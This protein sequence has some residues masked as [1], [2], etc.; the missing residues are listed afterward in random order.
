MSRWLSELWR[1]NLFME[2]IIAIYKPKG[3][4]SHDIIDEIR[5][6]TGEQR[7]GHAGTL[8]PLA[9][10]VLVVGIGREATKK[11]S[12]TVKKEKEYIAEI[13]FGAEST[14]DDEEGDK[15][16]LEI[17]ELPSREII[18]KALA[19][20]IGKIIQTPPIYSAIKVKGRAAYKSARRGEEIQ[21]KSREVE[22]KEIEMLQYKWPHLELRIVTGPGVYIR[23]LARDLGKELAVGGYLSD[24]ERIRVGNFRKGN[25]ITIEDLR[26]NYV[27]K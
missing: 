16:Y 17:K 3:P 15:T 19:K 22:I 25:S 18:E 24:L 4:T 13:T 26:K 8:D 14:T 10:G 12:E 27:K 20:F 7:V 9:R 1:F 2:N 6:I 11:L 23:A 21:L 5:K